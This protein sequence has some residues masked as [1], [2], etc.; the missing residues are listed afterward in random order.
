MKILFTSP[1]MEHPPA[2]GPRLRIENSI[3][4]LDKVSELYVVSRDE[5]GRLAGRESE[6]YFRRHCREFFYL[7]SIAGLSANRYVRK[8]QR[9][10]HRYFHSSHEAD[11]L[12]EYADRRKIEVIWF[13]YGNI[14]YDLIRKIKTIRPSLKVVCDTD[15]VWSRFVLRGLPFEKD[16]ARSLEIEREGKAKENEEK[17][18]VNL[19][20]VTTAVSEVDAEYYRG[21]ARDPR[22]IRIFSNVIN[23]DTY[24]RSPLPPDGFRKPCV[25]LAGSFDPKSPMDRAARWFIDEV[26]PRVRREIPGVHFYVAGNNSRE[27]LHDIR[28]PDITITSKVRSVL[29]YLCNADV[30]IVPLAFESGTRFKI[31]EAGICGIPIVS[32]T[33]GAEGIP[34]ADGEHIVIADDAAAFAAGVVRIIRDKPY[35]SRIAGNCKRLVQKNYGIDTLAREAGDI[36]AFL[37]KD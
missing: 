33:L 26:L 30:S 24:S 9:L 4:A 17:A 37:E 28:D 21:L 16:P 8:A 15:S 18:W 10:I 34:V 14:S 13:G 22:R 23:L 25:F 12:L 5:G 19:C 7:P 36:I 35:G 27:T 32:T 3:L 6:E 29:P 31:L 11:F 1:I 2:G 20:D